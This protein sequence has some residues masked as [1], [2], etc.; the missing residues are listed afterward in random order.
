MDFKE[1]GINH[2]EGGWPKEIDINESDQVDL[3]SE[4]INEH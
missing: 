2:I 1:D 4:I 3:I